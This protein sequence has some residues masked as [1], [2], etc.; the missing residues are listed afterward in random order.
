MQDKSEVYQERKQHRCMWE[1]KKKQAR[2][3][4]LQQ[5]SAPYLLRWQFSCPRWR[6]QQWS[7]SLSS[8]LGDQQTLRKQIESSLLLHACKTS[9]PVFYIMKETHARASAS[10]RKKNVPTTEKTSVVSL[11]TRTAIVT[12]TPWKI[13]GWQM[14]WTQRVIFNTVMR[15]FLCVWA[16]WVLS[17]R[18]LHANWCQLSPSHRLE[19]DSQLRHLCNTER[20]S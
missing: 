11:L 20:M 12:A 19:P 2:G 15:L 17:I 5:K 16:C 14:P 4:V 8:L 3:R 6:W 13:C 10:D 1:K 18:S 9:K 7:R